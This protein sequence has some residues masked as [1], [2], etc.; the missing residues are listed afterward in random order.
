MRPDL[1][2]H[3]VAPPALHAFEGMGAGQT[4][5]ERANVLVR[6]ARYFDALKAYK[7]AVEQQS[8]F[9]EGHL[10]CAELAHLM[11]DESGSADHFR[12]ALAIKRVYLDPLPLNDRQP[13][14]LLLRDAP[15]NVNAPLEMI[16]D[17][18]RVAIHKVF[19]EG[20]VVL[21]DGVAFCAFGYSA[22]A[23]NA[24]ARVAELAPRAV[25][26]PNVL[27]RC[28]RERLPQTLAGVDGIS[29]VET[30]R[31]SGHDLAS[32]EVPALVRP[33]DTHAGEGLLLAAEASDVEW[34]HQR[35]QADEYHVTRFVDYRS[36]D[37]Y[38]RKYRIVL[39]DG[40]AYPYHLA[41]ANRW[42]VHYRSSLMA[43]HEWMREEEAQF[44]SDPRAVFPQWD[45]I[46][47]AIA[48]HIGLDYLGLDVAKLPDGSMLIF[49]ADPAMLVHD[50]EP[51][52]QVASYKRPHV[53]VI[54][55]A[56]HALLGKHA[57]L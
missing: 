34:H 10:A 2:E 18:S 57:S 36:A 31:V 21:P 51:S 47:S 14:V 9:A 24:I 53:A 46:A 49:E 55:E 11:R 42:M 23:S 16:L 50:E 13:V 4:E 7:H 52:N 22:Q 12:R 29:I 6:Q 45:A 56:L 26:D 15:Y 40:V 48:K 54:R 3:T 41:I 30:A 43:Q 27:V 1:N 17:R 32:I 35:W 8:T 33:A 44:L 38:Y 39:V 5:A 37:G 20:S 19:V 25:N 28:A